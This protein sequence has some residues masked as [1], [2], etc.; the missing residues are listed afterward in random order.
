MSDPEC[1]QCGGSGTITS[2]GPNCDGDHCNEPCPVPEQCPCGGH[3]N[4]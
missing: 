2:H 1:E 4:E 3:G